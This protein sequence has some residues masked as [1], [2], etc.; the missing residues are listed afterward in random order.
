MFAKALLLTRPS[1]LPDPKVKKFPHYHFCALY[2]NE[3]HQYLEWQVCKKRICENFNVW[4]NNT[5]WSLFVLVIVNVMCVMQ[6]F[7]KILS[8]LCKVQLLQGI[9][10]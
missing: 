4:S 2:S 9:P 5:H 6:W 7:D 8:V 1:G 3:D 10:V